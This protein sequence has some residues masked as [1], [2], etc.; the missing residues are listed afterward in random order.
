VLCCG[1]AVLASRSRGLDKKEDLPSDRVCRVKSK[2][3][4]L[5]EV[6][7]R[8]EARR[9]RGV[10][11]ALASVH[12]IDTPGAAGKTVL[13]DLKPVEARRAG[14]RGVVDLGETVVLSISSAALL[15]AR[16]ETH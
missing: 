11:P 10:V 12:A 4:H 7:A 2:S 9:E 15:A 14:R 1:D 3:L 6:V 16:Q 13:A 5:E 8:S